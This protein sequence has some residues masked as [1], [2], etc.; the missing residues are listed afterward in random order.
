MDWPCSEEGDS[1]LKKG[2]WIGIRRA[3][4]GEVDRS[5]PGKGECWRTEE[6][7]QNLERV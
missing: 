3:T 1:F 6:I 7:R 4:G 2:H 5:K